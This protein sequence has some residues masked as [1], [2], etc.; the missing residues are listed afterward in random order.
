MDFLDTSYG[1][2]VQQELLPICIIK[3]SAYHKM[4]KSLIT[5][6]SFKVHVLIN[7]VQ[8]DWLDKYNV[9]SATMTLMTLIFL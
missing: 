3:Q 6:G 9:P 8:L 1:S 5:A 7:D 2:V 4:V